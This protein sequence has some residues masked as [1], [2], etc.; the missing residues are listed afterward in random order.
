MDTTEQYYLG[1]ALLSFSDFRNHRH[2][3]SI[4][5]RLLKSPPRWSVPFSLF[6]KLLNLYCRCGDQSSAHNLFDEMS[7]RDAVSYNTI[8]PTVIHGRKQVAEMYCQMRSDGVSPNNVTLSALIGVAESR[9]VVEK[10]HCDAVKIGGLNGEVFVGASL[11][12]GYARFSMMKSSIRAFEEIDYPDLVCWNVMLDICASEGDL[13][14][15][16]RF[17]RRMRLERGGESELGFDYFTLTS[18][19]KTCKSL[20]NVDLGKQLHG[21]SIRSGFFNS[22]SAVGNALLTMY[23]TTGTLSSEKIFWEL[24]DRT[25]VTWTAMISAFANHNLPNQALSFYTTMLKATPRISENQFCFATIL[26]AVSASTNHTLGLQI[27]ARALKSIY[28]LDVGVRNALI[29]MYFKCGNPEDGAAVFEQ[30]SIPDRVTWTTFISGLG[31]HGKGHEAIACLEQ[32]VKSHVRPDQVTFL[33]V[34]TACSHAGLV[35]EGGRVYDL[36]ISVHGVEPNGKHYACMV[37]LLGRAGKLK[38]AEILISKCESRSDPVFMSWETMAGMCELHGDFDLGRRST[39]K[40]MEYDCG[41]G[42]NDK[43]GSRFVT[44]ANLYAGCQMWNEKKA[45]RHILDECNLKKISGR[46]WSAI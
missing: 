13:G 26:S 3:S 20:A 41:A 6:N 10:L 7:E 44:L 14:K 43:I 17:L 18:I 24:Y 1:R 25:I 19:V 12:S 46:S 28:G 9:R 36:M 8:L 11:V 27:H 35:G 31:R 22:N 45:V 21:C 29:D 15:S 33:A 23:S 37:D 38:E 16:V 42:K 2:G 34:L 4:H 39:E 32:M 40:A 30:T 5:C